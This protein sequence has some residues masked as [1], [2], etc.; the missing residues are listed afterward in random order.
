[1]KTIT[2]RL[3]LLTLALAIGGCSTIVSK[4]TGDGPVG[5]DKT[6][7]SFG[8]LI[9][10]EIIETYVGANLLKADPG[11]QSAHLRAVSFNGI[12]LLVG[13]VKSEQL[14]TE[15]ATIA[16]QVRNVKRVHNELTVSGPI[17]I[18]ARTNDQ[19]L[20]TKI[21]SSM[22]ATK[23]INPL[24]VKVVVENGIIYLMGLVGK[25]Q[26]DLAV[27]ISRQTYGVQKIVKVFE[28]TD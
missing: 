2:T 3:I 26:A 5:T 10:D 23:G 9:D 19:W 7:R 17:S 11:Y 12:V 16:S 13:Q 18:P 4:T 15:A 21:K 14:L 25:P 24:E 6:E 22:L 1:M 28:Y 20:K 27:R 8:R